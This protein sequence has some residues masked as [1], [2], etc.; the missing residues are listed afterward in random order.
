MINRGFLK[1]HFVSKE[2]IS[3]IIICNFYAPIRVIHQL[4]RI[5]LELS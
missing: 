4:I 5:K 3:K 2:F 1:N